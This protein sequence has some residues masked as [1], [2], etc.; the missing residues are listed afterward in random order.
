MLRMFGQIIGVLAIL[1]LLAVMI[2]IV[3]GAWK[4][5]RILPDT[6]NELDSTVL[7]ASIT[8]FG[9]ITSVA[10]GNTIQKVY[11]EKISLRQKHID[12]KVEIYSNF[13]EFLMTYLQRPISSKENKPRNFKQDAQHIQRFARLVLI[14]GSPGVIKA[15]NNFK[16]RAGQASI[17]QNV[18][19][20]ER[21]I[22]AIRKDI[23]QTNLGLSLGDLSKLNLKD[24][25][26]KSVL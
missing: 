25:E 5:I 10:L 14:W 26:L 1:C 23:G 22:K 12:K 7:A 18:A 9:A 16:A 15:Y 4:V 8:V 13:I 17:K 19:H 2:I 11:G 20:Y 21:I 6:I 24:D 3:F